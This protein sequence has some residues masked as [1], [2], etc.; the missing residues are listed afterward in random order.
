MMNFIEYVVS[1]LKSDR[2]SK[3]NALDL[4]KQFSLKSSK[5]SV[6]AELH[7]LLHTN[8]SDLERQAFSSTFSGEEFFLKDHRVKI[9][10]SADSSSWKVL[11][12]VAYLE[13]VRAAVSKASVAQQNSDSLELHNIVWVQPVVVA[14]P[15]ELI[16]TL[17]TTDTDNNQPKEIGFEVCSLNGD[18][19]IVHCQGQAVYMNQTAPAKL[20][21]EQLKTQMQQGSLDSDSIYRAFSQMGLNYGPAFQGI[22]SIYQGNEQL[23][24]Q[25][26]LP[27]VVD[28]SAKDYLLHPSLMD[29]A[30]QASIG[31][32]QDLNLLPEHPSIPF[33]LDILRIYS[34]CT[35]NMF[36][37]VRFSSGSN[38]GDKVVKLDVDIVDHTGNIC[39]QMFGFSTRIIGEKIDEVGVQKEIQ[40]ILLASPVWQ[41]SE[42][43][44]S[45]N[46]IQITYSE[47]HIFLCDMPSINVKKL[48]TQIPDSQGLQFQSS[49]NNNIAERYNNIAHTCFKELQ[50][51]LENKPK[52]KVLLQVVI[53]NERESAIFSGISGL[54]KTAMLEFPQLVGQVILT[55]PNITTIDLARQL[56][57][58]QDKFQNT[59]IRY[60]YNERQ[61]LRWE[62]HQTSQNKLTIVFKDQGVYLITGGLGKL[63]ILLAKEILQQTSK[64]K[65]ILTGRTSLIGEDWETKKQNLFHEHLTQVEQ[66]DYQQLD[67]TNLIQVKQLIASIQEK[68]QQ[69]NGII[70]S[71]GI[72]SDSFIL[73]KSSEEFGRVLGPKVT[74]T[75]NL[76]EA[77]Q[78]ISLDFLLLF[79]SVS[80]LFGNLG[81]ADYA[82]ANGFIDQFSSYRNQMVADRKRHGATFSINWPLWEAGGMN[83]DRTSQTMLQKYTGMVPM[84]TATGLAA[85]YQSMSLQFAQTLVMEGDI[86]KL[87]HLLFQEQLQQP[88]ALSTQTLVTEVNSDT[89]IDKT[90][91]YIKKQLSELLKLSPHRIDSQAPLEKYGIDS[92]L[93]ME[94]TNKLEKTFGSL[95][96]TLFFEYQTI[97][98]LT[99]Y[100]V[101]SYATILIDLFT[102]EDNRVT[103]SVVVKPSES[104]TNTTSTRRTNRR[105]TL[106]DRPVMRSSA[107][108]VDDDPI[109]I[110]GLSGRYPKALNIDEYWQNLQEGKDC[111]T[112]V[113]KERWNWQ[114][115]LSE[116]R[117]LSGHHYSKWGGFIEGVDEFDPLFFNISPLE[118]ESIDPQERLFL[119]HAWMAVEDAGYTRSRLQI[120]DEQDSPGQVGVYVGVMY[121]EYQ[122][123]GAEASVKGKRIGVAG[124]Y[125]SIANRVSYVM[126]LHGPSMAID[127]M[128]SSSLASIHLACQDLKQ[129]RTSLAIAGGVNVSIHPSKY[130]VLSGGQFISSEGHCQ[131]F[132]EGGEGYIPGEGVG[133][134]VLKRLSEAQKDGDSIYGIIKGSTLNHGG[135][136]NGY[137]VPSPQ[138]QA[139]AISRTILESKIDPRHISYVEAHGTG[140][141]LGDPI[142]IAALSQAF[143]RTEVDFSDDEEFG[144][145][146]IG[147]AKSNIGHCESAAGVAGLTKVLL[148]MKHQQ[149]V[150]S[151]HSSQLNP[152]IDFE[153]SPFVVNQSLTAW[154]QPVINGLPL[155]RIAGI[156]SFGA[157]GSNAHLII[158][159]Y[160][161]IETA[162]LSTSN[163]MKT[164][165]VIIPLS[166][167][168]DEQLRQ[169][170]SDLLDFVVIS[171][172]PLNS[173]ADAIDLV[174][175]AYTLQTGR[176]A[177]EVRLG[178]MVSST[179]QLIEKLQAYKNDEQDIED[180]YYSQVKRNADGMIVINRDDDMKEA[181][182]KWIARKKLTKLLDL[183]VKGLEL[184]WDKF[185]GEVKPMRISLPTY[186]F[187]KNRYWLDIDVNSKH[188]ENTTSEVL[189]PLVHK[190][191]SDFN[192]QKYSTIFNGEEFFLKD[193]KVAINQGVGEGGLEQK[194]LPAV[195]YLEMIRAA[196]EQTIPY[197][198]PETNLELRNTVW[199]RPIVVAEKKQINI[200]LSINGQDKIDYEVYSAD[201]DHEIIYCQGQ[202]IFSKKLS[203]TKLD[204]QQ[205][206][207]QMSKESLE[208][209]VLYNTFEKM[210]IH[211][212]ITYQG[213]KEVYRGDDQ[214]LAQINLPSTIENSQAEYILHPSMMDSAIQ[215]CIGLKNDLNDLSPQPA[216]P[217]ALEKLTLISRCTTSMFAWVRYTEGSHRD[218][219]INK[220]DIDLCDQAGNVCVQMKGFTSK[221][222][223]AD[224]NISKEV[225][226][227]T[228]VN[229]PI[230]KL[231]AYPKWIS[232]TGVQTFDDSKSKYAAKHILLYNLPSVSCKQLDLLISNSQS[233]LLDYFS[234]KSIDARY[235]DVALQCFKIVQ[236][237]LVEKPKDNVLVQMVI[238]D[239]IEGS[240]LVGLS[241]LFKTAQLENP[242]FN[243]QI[244]LT[245]EKIST[246]ELAEQLKFE[247]N[248]PSNQ[249]IKLTGSGRQVLRWK[250]E[251]LDNENPQLIYKNNGTYIITG[252]LGGLGLLFTKEILNQTTDAKI[253]LTGRSKISNSIQ[254][255]LEQL[256][257]GTERIEYCQLDISNQKDT[258]AL[259]SKL[260]KK[261]NTINGIIHSA[262]VSLDN[263]ILKKTSAE[264]KQVLAPKVTGTYHLDLASQN[265]ELDFMVLF[266]SVAGAMGNIGQ[267]D[268]A[269]ANGFMDQ[270][271]NYR[272]ELV[273]INKRHGHTLSIN[274]PLWQEG[275][276]NI[277]K[278][279]QEILEKVVGVQP[280]KTLTGMQAFYDSLRLRLTQSVIMEGDVVKIG[281]ILMPEQQVQHK[282]PIIAQNTN[283]DTESVSITSAFEDLRPTIILDKTKKLLI[284]KLSMLLKIQGDEFDADAPLEDY[285]IDS[286]LSMKLTNELELTFGSL[287]KTLFFEYQ[288]ITALAGYFVKDHLATL[289][290]KIGGVSKTTISAPI[291]I[292]S[293][294]H[295][296]PTSI[297][298]GP[299]RFLNQANNKEKE[300]AI[301]G[302]SGKYP[303]ADNLEEFW[304]NLKEGKD[305][306]TEIPTERWDNRLYFDP[307]QNQAGKS[308][309]KWGGFINDVDKFDSLFFNISPRE[310]ELI[311]PQ[312]RLFIETVWKT[313]EDAGYS[314]KS[315]SAKQI[316][317]YVGVMYGQY[318]LFGA[319]AISRGDASI[320][321]S[322]FAS[323]A[324]RV[325]YFFDFHGP[326][327]ALDT[328]CSSSLTAIH[329]ACEEIRK[330]GVEAAIA[331]GVNVSVH[332]YKYINLSQGRFVSSDGKC[333]SFGE[334]G[335][336]YVPGEG[337]G[338]VLLKPLD[339][340]LLDG[341]HI[342]GLIKSSTINHGGKTNGYTVPNPNAQAQL[343][344]DALT[345]ANIS[346]TSLSYIE[347]HG[348][349]TSLGD[350][351]EITGLQK[352]FEKFT[353]DKQFCPIGS[354]KSNIGHL[355]SAAGIAAVTKVLLQI[356]HKQLVPS[357]HSAPL[358]SHINFKNSPFYV[359]DKL[360][361]WERPAE[362][363]RRIGVS[364]FGAGGSNSH[365]IIEEYV[366]SR[367]K[368]LT[369]KISEIFILSA[370]TKDNLY[371]YSEKYIDFLEK[372]K[373]LSFSELIYTS[374]IGRTPMNARLAII[375][376][377]LEELRLKLTEWKA[378][379]Q[380]EQETKPT[381]LDIEGVFYGNVK[382]NKGDAGRLI[383]GEAGKAFLQVIMDTR[384]L[385]QLAKLW[386]LGIEISWSFLYQD[387]KPKRLS[388]PTYPFTKVRHWVQIDSQFQP[389]NQPFLDND[390]NTSLN[391]QE[392]VNTSEEIN[393]VM[394]F[395]HHW[396]ELALSTHGEDVRLIYTFLILDKNEE[397]FLTLEKQLN[398]NGHQAQ[399]IL[400]QPGQDYREIAPNIYTLNPKN[401]SDF[402][403]LVNELR[404]KNRLPQQVIHNLGNV[405]SIVEKTYVE[406]I[407]FLE[408]QLNNGVYTLL[409]LTKILL[410]E[411]GLARLKILSVST[412]YSNISEPQNV[413]ISGFL[414]TLTLE[415]PKYLSK[416]LAF[417][418][419]LDKEP[420]NDFEK[421][422]VILQE[423]QDEKWNSGEIAYDIESKGNKQISTRKIKEYVR[424]VSINND[425]EQLP[426]KQNGVYL[427]TGGLG[428]LGFIFCKYLVREF[429][430]KLFIIGRSSLNRALTLKINQLKNY[431]TKVH[432][433]QA[434]VAK[435]EDMKAVVKQAKAQFSQING[436]LHSAG[437]NSNSFVLRKTKEE[438]D[439]VLEVKV[440]GTV[441]LD[442]ALKSENLDFFVLFSSIA[443]VTGNLGQCDYAYANQFLDAFAESRESLV[444]VNK[445]FGKTLSINWPF[446]KKGGM[447]ISGNNLSLI[448]EKTG[449]CPLPT[450]LGIQYFEE[451]L[452]SDLSQGVVLYGLP[453]KIETYLMREQKKVVSNELKVAT[454]STNITSI[455]IK[456]AMLL[457]KTE[458]YLKE[459]ISEEIKLAPEKIDIEERFE[460]FGIDSVMINRFNVNLERDLGDLPK[461]LIYEYETIEELA[462]YLT[463]E[464]ENELIA[465][466]DIDKSVSYASSQ[467]NDIQE[468]ES[469]PDGYQ[470][471]V[472]SEMIT[473]NIEG[474]AIIGVHGCYPQSS[475]LD[476]Y[477][478]NLKQGKD[479]IELVPESRWNFDE[480]YDPSPENAALGKIY[481]KWGGFLEDFDKFDPHFFN[482]STE[483]A[484]MIDPQE[485][486]FLGSVW[487]TIEE[488]GYTRDSLK[489]RFTKGKSADVG[490]FVGVTTN[491][492]HLLTS[493]EWNK[494][495]IVSPGALP[496]SIA[497]RVSYFFNFQGPSMPVDTAC[498]SSLVAIHLAC[499]SLK[500][501]ECQLAI[502]GGVN[503]YLHPSKYHSLCQRQMLSKSGKCFSFGGGDDG[504]V[505]GEGVGTVL[506]KP[507]R[508]AIEHQDYIH[509]VISAS[510][511]EH[512]GRS[513]GYS[514][515]NPNSQSS[516]IMHTLKKAEIHPE[517]IGYIEGHGTGTQLGDSLEIAALSNAFRSQTKEKQF[518]PI[519]SVKA[520][521]GH[522][523]SAAGIAGVAKILLQLK[524]QQLVP[525]I[526]SDEVNPNINFA[527]SPFYLQHELTP[528]KS[529]P[530]QPRRALINSFGAGGVNACAVIEE[531]KNE[532]SSKVSQTSAAHLAILSAKNEE[533]LQQSVEGLITYLEKEDSVQLADLCYTLQIGREAMQ[534]RLAIV[535]SDERTLINQLR[536][537][538]SQKS[539]NANQT[540]VIAIFR[541]NTD[542][543]K[544]IKNNLKEDN[545][546]LIQASYNPQDANELARLWTLGGEVEWERLYPDH[547]PL[548]ISLPTYPFVKERYWVSDDSDISKKITIKQPMVQLHPLISYNSSNMKEVSFSSLL[549]A[550]EFYAVDH[551]VNNESLFP[552]AGFLEIACMAGT[553]A[554]EQRVHKL[555][556]IIWAQPLS[557]KGGSQKVKTF[558][559]TIGKSIEYEIT[560]LDNEKEI[561]SHS[562]GRI[563]F[564]DEDTVSLEAT[565]NLSIQALKRQSI[566]VQHGKAHY[567]K[568]ELH[569][570]NYGPSFQTIQE[571]YI[572]DLYALSKLKI[573]EHLKGEFDQFILHPSIIDGALQTV[574]GLVEGEGS[575]TTYLPFAIDEIEFIRP[576]SQLCYAYVEFAYSK[577]GHK[578]ELKKFNVQLLNEQG[579]VLVQIRNFYVRELKKVNKI[580]SV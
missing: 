166:A 349:G 329:L 267:S 572:D 461:T 297:V 10:N 388:I 210:G 381:K 278:T 551:K 247:A 56:Q 540:S 152:H 284:K 79:S 14:E 482:I 142:E 84:Q 384:D 343:I 523:E 380:E 545:K 421:A 8:V 121:S 437:V 256:E 171:E 63:G 419:S 304:D 163:N 336:G 32:I 43:V 251:S 322:S 302:I 356:K 365:L 119:Q 505:P 205:L 472:Q 292:Q 371:N 134:V 22:I 6:I 41:A 240:L 465:L 492:Y 96:K 1:E 76:D 368:Y 373:E 552:G 314:K 334:G 524:H 563:F 383:K 25:L 311:D 78:N 40:S 279:S 468:L 470:Q 74:G 177:M 120:P 536:E 497:N 252:G 571:L 101:N 454:T 98:E 309:S 483:E 406:K 317:V 516:L 446:W 59:T 442:E 274:W 97:A 342:H 116:D 485:R 35:E 94:L 377:N 244:I 460:H 331:G 153:N 218:D 559:K 55:K 283:R 475:N 216:L 359:Q 34:A 81:Q 144:F 202:A 430:A 413:A 117:S 520:N 295:G 172:D 307:K 542:S 145:C 29:S 73:K 577:D 445:R 321:S 323:I 268:Y 42:I 75:Y 293:N 229:Q 206:K 86:F 574:L 259:L 408:E 179:E 80:S 350:P 474:I 305:C 281:K 269:V 451:F 325:S 127:T 296:S 481:C 471:V 201:A 237:I 222:L 290:E 531:Y 407:K 194:V 19:E 569:G 36:A 31:F 190:N 118:A 52:G 379:K 519:G 23:L 555:K 54:L 124:S 20:D 208:P 557:F 37:W 509:A 376:R 258:S 232:E 412:T 289:R 234:E 473:D 184:D 561:I 286:V 89:F 402:E 507:L 443:G 161:A 510:A 261:Y 264:F 196:I 313:I 364:S 333:R 326:S 434:D 288:T 242:K 107:V 428:G 374:Q 143:N 344:Y 450:E 387:M 396:K 375:C 526:H 245:D 217:F 508:Q 175:M 315:L 211:Y 435:S 243:G 238:T 436:V 44:A 249:I 550:N 401:S 580:S 431:G 230:G 109:S 543:S 452:Q 300:V 61:V 339:K 241:G 306:I 303:Q 221:A 137:T 236:E 198:E 294:E 77:S 24:A 162:R 362:N 330:G 324:N 403:K 537:W 456:P 409:H 154:K 478:D 186:P 511:F 50:K 69:L 500:R 579:D 486:L 316:G 125:A 106:P 512:S 212:G 320:T 67:V 386:S 385:E 167:R 266:S 405:D 518:C 82:S 254:I 422:R 102:I 228:E 12:G 513:S 535:T 180:V 400:V 182:D 480:F 170:V 16:T 554:G 275:G 195:A 308:Y 319:E 57:D 191:T 183:W 165:K 4:I 328:M 272:N 273:K 200:A 156:S 496:W 360:T 253:I 341:D 239:N 282:S 366:D 151:L 132:G 476:E 484:K 467:I 515:P 277:D 128:C 348:T 53:E 418:T 318:E 411:K 129:R 538:K 220:L 449:M 393:Q 562:E 45:I 71:A 363:P 225:A 68:Y 378:Y 423:F 87:E 493:E 544:G 30:L 530:N 382:L 158:E 219:K 539:S 417:H 527:N 514:A 495:N 455:N 93:A 556:D 576:L 351:I 66:I 213:L 427:I 5:K 192:Q 425:R 235:S 564:K 173:S 426:L 565:N 287:S 133:V 347:T 231:F 126:N 263:F 103:D 528:W 291:K 176:E 246:N 265:I 193:H 136:T 233:V 90:Q 139:S 26:R 257:E 160:Q 13:M 433:C 112:E 248:K 354:V 185:Y 209:K 38:P 122:L 215:A 399:I 301:V 207:I 338:A 573:A 444:Q 226:P 223:G 479:L 88:I 135:K 204:I 203:S 395:S 113:P 298:N 568:F 340:A 534:E 262:G 357:L 227:L 181:I 164:N 188:F 95:S 99:E 33:A 370:D 260:K 178:L 358:N 558:L 11:P 469:P 345:K 529:L 346:P 410:K 570:F 432:Y 46:E 503:L 532:R 337:I 2:L 567:K 72:I 58:N 501:K 397:L 369:P 521:I 398:T 439:R 60:Q 312:E 159:E 189:H 51:I 327:M 27:K 155:P 477:W 504:F 70:H 517:S 280:M 353:Q 48:E 47:R 502:A 525:S 111:I 566:K 424:E 138:A 130:L 429:N 187:A 140:T 115:Y 487:N 131:S 157:G 214:L 560:S 416:V 391:I 547:K 498:S 575:G 440:F 65:I 541:G 255:K 506:L 17:F 15:T 114:E 148:Q 414:K 123:F 169:K 490:V 149:I 335:D 404:S 553:I 361:E 494:G 459:L 332:P 299:K 147:S 441:N 276:M 546:T 199:I 271:A 83:V 28:N 310:A 457:E 453:S 146:L 489:Q 448:E 462:N 548:R 224:S 64:A 394:H 92:I 174:A 389:S 549:L 533:Q 270:F 458:N 390:K 108:S 285:G 415:N 100:F 392:Q 39:L 85:I 463:K 367:E 18:E 491:S 466:F 141:K 197:Q 110:I 62:T 352:A 420:L 91:D 372:N 499:E 464:A 438:M 488:A 168:T 105:A 3:Q 250:K 150:P 104:N 578:M 49:V 21:T 7:P 355:E 9:D 447:N 522:S